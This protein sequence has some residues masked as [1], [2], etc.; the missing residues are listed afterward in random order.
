MIDS[1]EHTQQ[2]IENAIC[3]L[4]DDKYKKNIKT[5]RTCKNT[6]TIFW[7]TSLNENILNITTV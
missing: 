2:F 5:K 3:E 4:K 1:K 6:K 7:S